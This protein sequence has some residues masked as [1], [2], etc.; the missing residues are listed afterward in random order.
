MTNLSTVV[1]RHP[2]MQLLREDTP[3][4]GEPTFDFIEFKAV[5]AAFN[6]MLRDQRYDICEMALI[7]FMQAVSGGAQLRM[8]PVVALGGFVHDCIRYAPA[9]GA[10]SPSRLAGKRIGV[11]AYSQT[12]AVWARGALTQQYGLDADSVQWVA[13]DEAHVAGFEDPPNVKNLGTREAVGDLLE[14][15]RADVGIL[16]PTQVPAASLAPLIPDTKSATAAW[17][18][19][20]GVVPVNHV[21]CVGPKV[22]KD[23]LLAAQVQARFAR[24]YAAAGLSNP[25]SQVAASYDRAM[26]LQ[27]IRVASELALQQHLI[28]EPFDADSALLKF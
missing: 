8:L 25:D 15:G 16:H 23:P 26:L 19:R 28:T 11:R 14:D 20:Y 5:G 10:Q 7:A 17:F 24:A 13:T 6:D 3:L 1:G 21:V 12:T 18:E 4:A 22:W 2:Q 27:A 9:L